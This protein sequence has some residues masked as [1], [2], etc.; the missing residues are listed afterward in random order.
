MPSLYERYIKD[1]K[2]NAGGLRSYIPTPQRKG[3]SLPELQARVQELQ[4]LQ[5]EH[6]APPIEQDSPGI[7]RRIIDVLSR[8]NYAIAG[9]ADALLSSKSV[10]GAVGRAMT[11]FFS[12]IGGLEGQKEEWGKVLEDAGVGTKTLADVFPLLE[13]TWVGAFGSRGAA[14]LSLNVLTDPLTYLSGGTFGLIKFPAKAGAVALTKLGA[15]R[16]GAVQFKHFEKIAKT[17]PEFRAAGLAD[18]RRAARAVTTDVTEKNFDKAYKTALAEFES[19]LAQNPDWIA[20]GGLRFFG[21]QIPGTEKIMPVLGKNIGNAIRS[22]PGGD[23][24]LKGAKDFADNLTASVRSMFHPFNKLAG[25]P[26]EFRADAITMHRRYVQSSAIHRARLMN[27]S[28]HVEDK[29]NSV[30]KKSYKGDSEALGKK[31]YNVRESIESPSILTTEEHEIFQAT[32]ELYDSMFKT[33]HG[34][35]LL[36]DASFQRGYFHHRYKND[37]GDWDM[38]VAG[39]YGTLPRSALPKHTR[40]REFVSYDESIDISTRLNKITDGKYPILEPN[41]DVFSNLAKYVDDHSHMVALKSWHE[42]A[43][44]RFGKVL[45]D[46]DMEKYF[47]LDSLKDIP[48]TDMQLIRGF[49]KGKKSVQS[50]DDTLEEALGRG[51]KSEKVGLENFVREAQSVLHELTPGGRREFFTKTFRGINSPGQF[52][53]ITSK[54]ESQWGKYFPDA[55][56]ITAGQ[57]D[58]AAP[59]LGEYVLRAPGKMW[60]N[61]FVHIPGAIAEDIEKLNTKIIQSQDYK[62]FT[63]LLRGFDWA[64]N[65][66]KMG[67]YSLWPASLTRDA[68][69]N[70]FLSGLDIGLGSINPRVN[71]HAIGIMAKRQGEM[72]M[73]N[74]IRYDWKT[75]R[76]MAEDFGVLVPGE[77]FAELTGKGA[78]AFGATRMQ[79]GM[80]SLVRGRA[81]VENEAR[82]V[83]WLQNMRRGA[84]PLE[85]ANRV[86]DFLFNYGEVSRVEREFFRRLIPFYTFTRKNVELQ[87]K[88]LRSNP[89]RVINQLKPFRGLREDNESLTKWEAEALKIRLDR[90]G[91]TVHMLTGIDLPLRNLDTLWSGGVRRTVRQQMG[92]ITP[93][94]KTIPELALN[95]QFFLGRDITRVESGAAGRMIEGL[96]TPQPVKNWLGYKKHVDAAGRPRYTF[97]GPRFTLLFKSWVASRAL[98]TADR[99]FREYTADS[100]WSG[101]ALDLLTGIREREADLDEQ[102]RRKL[103]ERIRML[104]ESLQRRGVLSKY[105]KSYQPKG[106]AEF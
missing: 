48:I 15:T 97:D 38:V 67:V 45:D 58:S 21:K 22:V 88:M 61:K 102:T 42:E 16:W 70:L 73:P 86:G 14:G 65:W 98:S 10:S 37:P 85:A 62:G 52:A 57:I 9:F 81:Q 68:Y 93:L 55:K 100:D 59:H 84:D 18:V 66:F 44:S 96:P 27:I 33:A 71:M 94:L 6:G 69:S 13:G 89:G 64:N 32:S 63:K 3:A 106:E 19:E 91:K 87:V 26:K 50:V 51:I 82:M 30:I 34:F 36:D 47:S 103:Y 75:L 95:R 83:L 90:D 41:Y 99:Q 31:F 54:M 7:M 28:R 17:A 46:F 20:K 74:N 72:V 23:E 101:M 43:V 77:V 1:R 39:Q 53:E 24:A 2:P 104:E 79:R 60:G 35:G 92:M 4:Q 76:K 49:F 78:R 5:Q 12:G 29:F 8:P 56:A 11:E 105:Q 25:L 40:A 80:R